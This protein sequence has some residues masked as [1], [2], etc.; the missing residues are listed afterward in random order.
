VTVLGNVHAAF[1]Y[2]EVLKD[3][4]DTLDYIVRGEGE[5][6]L[7]ELLN[8][9]NAGGDPVSVNGLAFWRNDAVVV[10]PKAAYI[11]DL[12]NLPTAWDLVEWPIYT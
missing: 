6:T 4:H 5:A 9:L 10:T 2:D 12:D 11:H 3:D 8:C 1:C 7:V